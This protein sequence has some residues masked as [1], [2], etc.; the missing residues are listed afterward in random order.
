MISL[1]SD[2][3]IMY[4][5]ALIS[6]MLSCGLFLSRQLLGGVRHTLIWASAFALGAVQWAAIAAYN[7]FWHETPVAFLGSTWAGGAIAIMLYA[8]FRERAGIRR[9]D[10]WMIAAAVVVAMFVIIPELIGHRQVSLATPQF[11]RMLFMS[12]TAWTLVG[13]LM[14]QGQRPS[15]VEWMAAV[16]MAALAALSAYVGYMRIIDCGCETNSARV[17][18]LVGLPVLYTGTG[19]ATVLL[20]AADLAQQ[21]H[22]TARIDPLTEV[23]NR[24]GFDE[25]AQRLMA[26]AR[27]KHRPMSVLIFDL[28]H[29]KAV[30]DNFGHAG[31]D[32]VL[33]AV[34][35]CVRAHCR[36]GDTLGRLG[37]EEFAIL[38]DNM[39][40]LDAMMAAE[41]IRGELAELSILPDGSGVTASFGVAPVFPDSVLAD[42]IARA[43]KALYRAKAGGRNR[44]C[45]YISA[46]E[47]NEP[48]QAQNVMPISARQI[49]GKKPFP[50][51]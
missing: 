31:G 24:R 35:D 43:D 25:A 20:L 8:G 9:R 36:A 2:A 18:L 27:R 48:A 46:V 23:L 3:A 39:A 5:L 14:R 26:Q 29:F 41:R 15:G 16:L 22:R 34:A 38:A 6:A 47:E 42:A 12:L 28:D 21:L 30:N 7:S 33:R 49:A 11:T 32:R 19:L 51:A 4:G 50:A 10:G 1:T 37:G 17:V 40:P 45:L 44:A 13:P